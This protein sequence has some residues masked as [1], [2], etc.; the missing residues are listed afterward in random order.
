MLG[1]ANQFSICCFMDSHFYED[2]YHSFE[3]LLAAGSIQIFSPKENIL[4][5]LDKFYYA[6]DDWIFGHFGY[7]LKN[8]IENLQSTH[9]NKI[10][11]PDIFLFQPQ[12]VISLNENIATIAAV[13]EEPAAVFEAV[14]SGVFYLNP[15][16]GLNKKTKAAISKEAYLKII[17]QL[18]KHILRGDC[19]EI[20]FCQEF[21]LEDVIIDPYSSYMQLLKI[22]PSPFSC[23]YKLE[24]K[25]LLCASP[26]RYLSKKGQTVF[27]Q[28][29]KGTAARNADAAL[30]TQ[31]KN[32][33]Y[34][35]EKEKSENVM[36]VDLVR[37]DLSKICEEGS[38]ITDELFGIYSFPQVHQMISTVKGTL[39]KDIPMSE[40][41]KATFPM[42][43]MTGAPKRRVMQLIEQYEKTKRQLFSGSVG[44]ITP[45]KDFD[46]N[47]VIRSIFY[48]AANRYLN[49]LVGGG[50]TFYAE[51]E[52][53]Y[54]ECLLKAQAMQAVLL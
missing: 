49:Y 15:A 4:E 2:K 27:S 31:E 5:Q 7:D 44:Y 34:K 47:V 22:S 17:Q 39:K 14:N 10:G 6:C 25:Y 52:K 37:N 21:F 36:I 9:E 13:D 18:K 42:G 53:E 38:V 20:N 26:E 50:I 51:G 32:N 19:Y 11:F 45:R 16:P 1:W 40:I 41:I 30:D 23:F 43:S 54:E 48:N 8:E 33:L 46:F 28:P 3:C 29:I 35:N 12:I 24:N